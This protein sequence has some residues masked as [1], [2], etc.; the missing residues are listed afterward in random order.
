MKRIMKTSVILTSLTLSALLATLPAQAKIYK[1]T[2]ANG[3][4]HY[5]AQPPKQTKK[6][7]IK[8][9]N[10][11]AEIKSKAGKYRG[12]SKTAS[13]EK[14]AATPAAETKKKEPELA[15]PDKQLIDYCKGQRANVAQLKKNFRTIWVDAKG[16]K[17]RLS[18][19]QRKEKVASI[20]KSI[21][22]TCAEVKTAG[23]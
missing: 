23:Q 22:E 7:A 6:S 17:T 2:D 15:G 13:T 16:K 14:V 20:Q 10:I 8:A 3:Q 11:E 21:D 5:T 4:V 12:P 18:Q 1:W 9:K 19:A